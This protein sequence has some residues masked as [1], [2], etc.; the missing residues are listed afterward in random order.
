MADTIRTETGLVDQTTGIFR[1]G[2]PDNSITAQDMR[3]FIVSTKFLGMSEMSWE[4][5]YD[6]QYTDSSTTLSISDGVRTQLT[7]APNPGED[8]KYPP[9]AAPAPPPSAPSCWDEVSN[10]IQ[11]PGLNS[12]GFIRLSFLSY[13]N[14]SN[15]RFDLEMDVSATGQDNTIYEQTSVFA[16]GAGSSNTEGF[17][18]IIPLFCGQDFVDNGGRFYITPTGGTI[19]VFR[20]TLTMFK[21]FAPNPAA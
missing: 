20:T 18:F 5:V 12:F 14:S 9:A 8:L 2:Q 16:K 1:D 10:T 4:F 13:P 17:N 7:I 21:A 11:P 6:G 3:D 19:E 15:I